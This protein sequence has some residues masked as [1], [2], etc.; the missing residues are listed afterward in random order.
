MKSVDRIILATFSI[1]GLRFVDLPC[2]PPGWNPFG[3]FAADFIA[4]ADKS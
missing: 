2:V 3:G 4:Q 1:G